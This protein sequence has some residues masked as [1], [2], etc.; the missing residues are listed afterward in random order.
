M[1]DDGQ[2]STRRLIESVLAGDREKFR[3]LVEPLKDELFGLI[4]RQVGDA[5]VAEDL[6]QE[7]FLRAYRSLGKFQFQASFKTWVTRIALNVVNTY[8]TSRAFRDRARS[9][10]FEMKQHEAAANEYDPAADK[11]TE[12]LR[13]AIA[14]LGQ[15]HRDVVTLCVL[16]ER[17]YQEVSEILGIPIG[18][19]GS[20]IHAALALLHSILEGET[21]EAA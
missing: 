15:K 13:A 20:R 3:E 17:S 12:L 1:D 14:S 11:N 5:T 7:T 4:V 8:F 21:D 18:T 16:E 19:V 9:V 6:T 2:L 10:P